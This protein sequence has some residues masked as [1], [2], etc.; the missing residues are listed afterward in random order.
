MNIK[1][2]NWKD[3]LTD[4]PFLRKDIIEIQ[5][6]QNYSK[7]NLNNFHHLKNNLKVEDDGKFISLLYGVNS[8]NS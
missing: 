3:L 2:K 1:T 6:P 8:T 4:E 7:F 5:D